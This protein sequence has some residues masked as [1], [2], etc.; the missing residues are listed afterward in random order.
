MAGFLGGIAN[1]LFGG[2]KSAASPYRRQAQGV[3]N[4]MGPMRNT[5]YSQGQEAQGRYSQASPQYQQSVQNLGGMLRQ[6]MGQQ[7]RTQVAQRTLGNT[8]PAFDNAASRLRAQANDSG[9]GNNGFLAGQ[10]ASLEGSRAGSVAGA[11]NQADQYADERELSYAD[12]LQ[13]LMGGQ[14]DRAQQDMYRGY[15]AASDMDRY[16]ISSLQGMGRDEEEEAAMREQGA[17]QQM[18]G[19][20]GA[21]SNLYGGWLAGRRKPQGPQY[22]PGY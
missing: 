4:G 14:V 16:R 17:M 2:R 3:M 7:G 5:Y 20:I 12:M 11:L 22:G 10:M 13:Q 19:L 1:G 9:Q 8:M 15:G 18:M 6:R 21:G